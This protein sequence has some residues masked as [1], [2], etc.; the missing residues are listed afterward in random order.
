MPEVDGLEATRRIRTREAE[1]D[2]T[3][4]F[5]IALT[6]HAMPSDREQSRAAG[7][8]GFLVKPIP[9]ESL[10]RALAAV[11]RL[12]MESSTDDRA[13][14]TVADAA[15]TRFA[16]ARAELNRASPEQWREIDQMLG[17]DSQLA[18]EIVLLLRTEAIRL[19]QDLDANL[20]NRQA[21]EVRRAAHTLK[22]NLRN[23]GAQ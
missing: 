18:S 8:N 9:M 23:V 21:R 5:I 14:V 4:A 22:S 17:G 2:R 6:A 10:R 12:S 19:W 15:F 16:T 3:P 13:T 1:L 20:S 7:M 11:P